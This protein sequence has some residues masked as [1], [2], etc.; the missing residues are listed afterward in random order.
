MPTAIIKGFGWL[1]A[2][3]PEKGLAGFCY[4]LGTVLA[5]L[6][7]QRRR[8]ALANLHHAFPEKPRRWHQSIMR[9]SL[10]RLIEMTLLSLA[11]MHFCVDRVRRMV[12]MPEATR[13]AYR[14]IL[15]EKS[16]AVIL[17]PHL[18]LL[19]TLAFTPALMPIKR[20]VASLFRP[21]D[22]DRLNRL[23]QQ[24]RERWGGTMLS[25]KV[26]IKRAFNTLNEGGFLV[27]F[28]DQHAGRHGA[29][30][31]FFG[32]VASASYL[33]GLLAAR[34]NASTYMAYPRRTGF[35]R[36]E[37]ALEALQIGRASCRERV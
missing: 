37:L 21:F 16:G 11:S 25:R 12:H 4:G 17:T 36:V 35:W 1:C 23:I 19:E 34:C 2:H 32:R 14:N 3:L 9:Q 24:T 22:N 31:P 8:I 13:Q 29:L 20:S 7:T 5:L 18:S 15:Q 6:P 30:I 33:P 26:G 27:I 10:R 28:L